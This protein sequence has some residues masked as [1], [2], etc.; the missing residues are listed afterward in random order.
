MEVI[1]VKM[2]ST[3]SLLKHACEF[4]YYCLY[5]HRLDTMV[6]KYKENMTY[7]QKVKIYLIIIS[8]PD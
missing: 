1:I 7:P 8:E 2:F 6:P 5:F 3:Y 4:I